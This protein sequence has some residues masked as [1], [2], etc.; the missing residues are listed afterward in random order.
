MLIL[1][2]H[3]YARLYQRVQTK[4]QV[5]TLIKATEYLSKVLERGIIMVD[6]LNQKL[7]NYVDTL[8]IFKKDPRGNLVFVTVKTNVQQKINYYSSGQKR[9]F[10]YKKNFMLAA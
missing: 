2:K 4:A 10:E 1:T 8:Y 7:V 5:K 9:S 3:G 6:D